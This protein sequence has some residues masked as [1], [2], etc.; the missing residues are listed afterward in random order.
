[1]G[2]VTNN[3]PKK[4][5]FCLINLYA[6]KITIVSGARPNFMKIAP[7]APGR[8]TRHGSWKQIS[9]R[10]RVQPGDRIISSL[11]ILLVFR[12]GHEAAGHLSGSRRTRPF[13]SG[14]RAGGTFAFER[15]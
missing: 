4:T 2:K 5:Y 15:D 12:P 9:Y 6:M 8:Q 11:D 10:S 14:G 13:G 7:V 3:F 1:M